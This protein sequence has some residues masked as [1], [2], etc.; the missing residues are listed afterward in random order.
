MKTILLITMVLFSTLSVML[1]EDT[2]NIK[3]KNI[4]IIFP[5]V[6]GSNLDAEEF[7][8]PADFQGELNIVLVAFW[9]EQQLDINT[10]LPTARRLSTEFDNLAYYELPTIRSMNFLSQWY[11]NNGMR[12]G[13]PD[14]EAR[15]T[16]ITLYIDKDKFCQQLGIESQSTIHTF[17][18]KKDGSVLWHDTGVHTDDK[19]KSLVQRIKQLSLSEELA[20]NAMEN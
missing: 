1:A 16:T 18:V 10:W 6:T 4:N 7:N 19:E 2:M 11:I 8:L 5:T 9:R 12:M 17:L 3:D 20:N 15:R 14:P 13:I